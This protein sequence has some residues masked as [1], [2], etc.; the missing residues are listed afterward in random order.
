MA[1]RTKAVVKPK[2]R[3]IAPTSFTIKRQARFLALLAVGWAITHAA[4]KV[5]ISRITAYELRERD[6]AFAK[7]WEEAR[8]S[9]KERLE[10]EASRRAMGW[11]EIRVDRDGNERETF[12][13]SDTLMI[14]LLKAQDPKKYRDQLDITLNEKRHITI[15]LV[16]VEKDKDSGRLMLVDEIQPPLLT[17]GEG[18]DA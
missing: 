17:S 11:T 4:E 10:E 8:D 12:N 18:N 1:K 2:G 14:F 7:L 6:P 3:Q 15:D 13:Y 9:G 5:G 16:Q